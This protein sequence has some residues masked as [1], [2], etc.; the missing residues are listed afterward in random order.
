MPENFALFKESYGRKIKSV[1]EDVTKSS[2]PLPLKSEARIL[3]GWTSPVVL[4]SDWIHDGGTWKCWAR[5][6]F[7]IDGVYQTIDDG[8][9]FELHCATCQYEPPPQGN[10]EQ[11]FAIYRGVWELVSGGGA[12]EGDQLAPMTITRVENTGSTHPQIW[13]TRLVRSGS[14]YLPVG[15]EILI[16]DP[17][18]ILCHAKVGDLLFAVYREGRTEAIRRSENHE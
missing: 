7:R 11:V 9:E 17:I 4:T 13:A 18:H 14:G 1:V 15:E 10:G 5:R 12:S 2:A 6:L 16:H 3:A 8:V